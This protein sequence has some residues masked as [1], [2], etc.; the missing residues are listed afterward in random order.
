MIE[1]PRMIEMLRAGVAVV[2][3]A[4]VLCRGLPAEE[5]AT[6]DGGGQLAGRPAVNSIGMKLVRIEPGSFLMGSVDGGD[7]DERPAHR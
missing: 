6:T 5:S 2:C 4:S 7:F 1:R 3:V